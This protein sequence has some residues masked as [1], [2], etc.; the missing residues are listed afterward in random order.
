MAAVTEQPSH[1]E[2]T[3]MDLLLKER[4][5]DQSKFCQTWGK[6]SR[7]RTGLMR[8]TQSNPKA[9][10]HVELQPSLA[11][12][13]TA[14]RVIRTRACGVGL[15][16]ISCEQ[17]SD[18]SGLVRFQLCGNCHRILKLLLLNSS[19]SWKETVEGAGAGTAT[20]ARALNSSI[21]RSSASTCSFSPFSFSYVTSYW[22]KDMNYIP[23]AAFSTSKDRFTSSTAAKHHSSRTKMTLGNNSCLG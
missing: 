10:E 15:D 19:S 5:W 13:S 11:K 17:L 2:L 7:C 9:V 18:N 6:G 12:H 16:Q 21:N 1:A 14:C 8:A 23:L 3:T 20:S 22:E 4:G